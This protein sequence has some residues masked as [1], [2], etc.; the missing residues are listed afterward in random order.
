GD[1][2]TQDSYVSIV[3]YYAQTFALGNQ[4]NYL[5]QLSGGQCYSL[6]EVQLH[7]APAPVLDL[8]VLRVPAMGALQTVAYAVSGQPLVSANVEL[9]LGDSLKARTVAQQ[10]PCPSFVLKGYRSDG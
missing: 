9:A 6:Q 1:A 2:S 7:L 8:H 5:V 4:A 3:P 10:V